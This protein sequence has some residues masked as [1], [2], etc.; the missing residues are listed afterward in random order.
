MRAMNLAS[1]LRAYDWIA[2]VIELV[3]VVVGILI[4]LQVSNWNQDRVEHA[5]AD[6]YYRR[7][8][9]CGVAGR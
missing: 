4:A 1:R 9:A 8:P 6:S 2:A 7:A 5:R 3:I